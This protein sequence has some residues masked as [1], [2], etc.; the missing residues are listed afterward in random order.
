V[1]PPSVIPTPAGGLICVRDVEGLFGRYRRLTDR[2]VLIVRPDRYV[3]DAW[4]AGTGI[5]AQTRLKGLFNDK[6]SE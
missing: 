6:G 1:T 3:A 4:D 2:P 5:A